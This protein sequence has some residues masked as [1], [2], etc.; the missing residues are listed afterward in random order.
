MS[1]RVFWDTNILVY[2][3]DTRHPEKRR[4]AW[5]LLDEGLRQG[6][7]CLSWQVLQEFAKVAL[8]KFSVPMP[9]H[10]LQ[11]LLETVL[12]PCCD[13]FPSLEIHTRALNIHAQTQYRFYDSL[14][15]ASALAAKANILYSED[16]QEGRRIEGLEI[17]NPFRV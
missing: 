7:I 3:F 1:D 9:V 2:V 6:S 5:S 10:E 8:H 14:I 15:V 11:E 13:I 12:Y 16:L 17:V 4:R